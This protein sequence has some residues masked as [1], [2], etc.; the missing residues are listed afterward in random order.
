[1]SEQQDGLGRLASE[2]DLQVIAELFGVVKPDFAAKL[3]E[4]LGDDLGEAVGGRLVV[5]GRFDFDQFADGGDYGVTPLVEVGKTLL[6]FA[7]SG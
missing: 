1:M 3:G 7:S 5:A 4:L 6:R 2:V